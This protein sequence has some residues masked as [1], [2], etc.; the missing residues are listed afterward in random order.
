MHQTQVGLK[1]KN[2]RNLY[3][4]LV[5][6]GCS[7]ISLWVDFTENYVPVISDVTLITSCLGPAAL[8]KQWLCWMY[9]RSHQCEWLHYLKK[10]GIPILWKSKAQRSVMPSSSAKAEFV[11]CAWAAKVAQ[12]VVPVPGTLGRVLKCEQMTTYI[13]TGWSIDRLKNTGKQVD[14]QTSSI[15]TEQVEA[16]VGRRTDAKCLVRSHKH[17]WREPKQG[18]RLVSS[19]RTFERSRYVMIWRGSARYLDHEDD[20]D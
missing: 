8:H 4:R 16:K 6:C 19:R 9:R 14:V 20:Q 17:D 12:I 10:L 1:N 7:Q 13:R 18:R 5:S 11:P 2:K 3:A 15:R